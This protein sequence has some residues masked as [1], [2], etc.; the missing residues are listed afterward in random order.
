MIKFQLNGLASIGLGKKDKLNKKCL[1]LKSFQAIAVFLAYPK[2]QI[3]YKMSLRYLYAFAV[4]Y[5]RS[6]ST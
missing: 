3:L 6:F 5:T 4:S 1:N 2:Y